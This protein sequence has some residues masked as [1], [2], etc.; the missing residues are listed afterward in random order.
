MSN[1]T[2]P[3]PDTAQLRAL[4]EA[5]TRGK[6]TAHGQMVC[7]EGIGDYYMAECFDGNNHMG[8]VAQC[9]G[10][11]TSGKQDDANAAY[12]AAACNALPALLDAYDQQ[13]AELAAAREQIAALLAAPAVEVGE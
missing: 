2:N 7:A 6:W 12:I 11:R 13:A 8:A 9:D 5:A 4:A 1:P 10:Q 3:T